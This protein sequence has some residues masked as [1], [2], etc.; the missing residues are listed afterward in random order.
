[1]RN[2]KNFKKNQKNMLDVKANKCFIIWSNEIKGRFDPLFLRYQKQK[3]NYKFDLVKLNDLLKTKPQYGANEIAI[4]GD[5]NTG[6]RYIRITDIDEFGNLKK[7]SWQTAKTIEGK[8]L[9]EENDILFARSGAT[10]GKSFIYKKKF[11]KAIFAGYLIKFKINEEKANPKF[12][13]YY[14]QLK[15]YKEWIKSIQRPS[16]QPNI[17]SEEFKEIDIPLPTLKTQ[18]EIVEIM[19]SAYSRKVDKEKEAENILN[20]ADDYILEELE[21]KTTKSEDKKCFC[22]NFNDVVNNRLDPDFYKS[23]ISFV[24]NKSKKINQKCLMLELG[25]VCDIEKGTSI[26]K[27]KISEGKIPVIAGGQQPAY[28]NNQ[29]NRE[30]K[31]ITVSASGAYS[32]FVN[33]FDFPIFASDCTTIK[34]KDENKLLTEF[35]FYILKSKQRDIY[36]LQRGAGQPHVYGK[37]LAKITIPI[38]SLEIQKKLTEEIRERITQANELKEEAKNGIEKAKQEV[39]RIILG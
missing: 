17:N 37:E 29:N 6:T 38:P 2:T 3:N 34:A 39:E 22:I 21:I 20:S 36:K 35:V 16:G 30:G 31:T 1:M 7:A 14:T 5:P 12:I 4:D 33:Y 8:Y 32:G 27:E 11:G 13:F 18:G 15:P 9:L 26:T 19:Q 23:K 24:K 25:K 10:A 28:Y